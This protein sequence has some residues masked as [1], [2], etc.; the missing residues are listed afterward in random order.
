MKLCPIC[1]GVGFTVTEEVRTA[2]GCDGT[3]QMC[4][5]V[6][7]VPEQ[8]Q[9]Q[10]QCQWCDEFTQALL[11]A[12]ARGRLAENEAIVSM[13]HKDCV[14]ETVHGTLCKAHYEEFMRLAKEITSRQRGLK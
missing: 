1:G 5:Q 3:E 7:P 11:S 4:A 6:C 8:Y 9:E 14:Q 10:H 12:E 13:I 2:H